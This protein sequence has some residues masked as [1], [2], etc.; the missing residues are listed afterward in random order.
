MKQPCSL[1]A[2]SE[3]KKAPSCTIFRTI[4]ATVI[5]DG[6]NAKLKRETIE[7]ILLLCS[8]TTKNIFDKTVELFGEESSIGIIGN[9]KLNQN[10]EELA[11]VLK[12]NMTSANEVVAKYIDD[13]FNTFT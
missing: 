11:N 12:P 13:T 8:G 4:A 1:F 5:K 2:M 6:M 9:S 7:E 10:L 3:F